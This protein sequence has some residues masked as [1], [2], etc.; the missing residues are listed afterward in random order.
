MGTSNSKSTSSYS[1][2]MYSNNISASSY[3]VKIG[4][5]DVSERHLLLEIRRI[6]LMDEI[7]DYVVDLHNLAD[8]PLKKSR[9]CHERLSEGEL[10]DTIWGKVVAKIRDEINLNGGEESNTRMQRRFRN[11]FRVPFSM[12]EEMIVEC[13]DANIFGRTQIPVEFKLLGCLRVLGRGAYCDDVAE[14][15]GCG[16]TT[17][18][19]MFKAFVHKYSEAYY[20]KYV[21]VPEGEEMD[22][23]MADYAKMGFPGC[24]GSMDVTH[25]M[26]KQCPSALRHVCTG[27]YHAPSVAFQMVCAHTRRI[28]HVSRPFYGATNDITIT[29]NDTY[30]REVMHGNVHSD[31]VFQTYDR[32]G[33]LR[34]WRGAYIICDGGYP[35]C[36]CFVDPSL[37]DYEYHTVSWAE[38]LESV[39]KDVERLFGALKMR[40]RWISKAIE[41]Q[42]IETLGYAVKVAAILHN[43][44]LAYDNFDTFNWETM[45]P[46]RH[47]F[48]DEEQE[49]EKADIG[50]L[51]DPA[52]G[53]P[54]LDDL[55]GKDEMSNAVH[56]AAEVP[57]LAEVQPM[58]E[59][60]GQQMADVVDVEEVENPIAELQ[61]WVLKEALRNHFSYAY[62]NG[63]IAWPK[64]F[65]S[66]Q[67]TAMP[68]LQVPI[69]YFIE[70]HVT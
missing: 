18:N 65:T 12:F 40:F 67:K 28:H 27:R 7:L 38:W 21:Y 5:L 23:V 68:L 39:R 53:E 14:I 41:Y 45:D 8:P 32:A 70:N 51:E 33:V 63:Q 22:K 44:L 50:G 60:L 37:L 15:L 52:V 46:N 16:V 9:A 58:A 11:R 43:R 17:V 47:D 3:S 59:P 57:I 66:F 64:R 20:D 4:D 36:V 48:E 55:P 62:S 26:W 19:T 34:T 1:N 49:E 10:W 42:D 56:S 24:V 30:P 25:L 31:I 54:D 6:I 2:V 29:Y 13:K 61:Q 35:K 69:R